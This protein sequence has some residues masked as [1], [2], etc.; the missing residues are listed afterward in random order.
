M[1]RYEVTEVQQ[2][3]CEVADWHPGGSVLGCRGLW[4]CTQFL[5]I[6]FVPNG[7]IGSDIFDHL[8]VET[9]VSKEP[10]V[11][12]QESSHEIIYPMS[13]FPNGNSPTWNWKR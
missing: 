4:H 9:V 12:L 6:M 1:A 5:K 13:P 8:S 7:R 11:N 3:V 2:L 10:Y